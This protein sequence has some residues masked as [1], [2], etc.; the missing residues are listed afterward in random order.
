MEVCFTELSRFLAENS[1]VFSL[2]SYPFFLPDMLNVLNCNFLSKDRKIANE[3][4]NKFVL[5]K[6]KKYDKKVYINDTFIMT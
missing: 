5:T 4:Y 3:Y 6:R 1:R 2:L